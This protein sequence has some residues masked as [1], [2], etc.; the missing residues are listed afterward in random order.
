MKIEKKWRRNWDEGDDY[1]KEMGTSKWEGKEESKLLSALESSTSLHPNS[2][3]LLLVENLLWF[4]WKKRHLILLCSWCHRK[5]SLASKQS[6]IDKSLEV[7][8]S[9]VFMHKW[10]KYRAQGAL[11]SKTICCFFQTSENE[12][13]LSNPWSLTLQFFSALLR[14]NWQTILQYI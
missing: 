6:A 13:A 12:F 14:Y 7:P 1:M 3:D 4:W 8:F 9:P 2:V 11:H 10:H 5:T